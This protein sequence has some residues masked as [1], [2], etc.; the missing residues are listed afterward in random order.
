KGI[1]SYPTWE[2]NGKLESGVKPLNKLA[3]LSRYE[4]TRQF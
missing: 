1:D 3:E 4:G 2:I